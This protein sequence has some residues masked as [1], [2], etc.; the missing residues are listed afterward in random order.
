MLSEHI[1]ETPNERVLLLVTL[2]ES[3]AEGHMTAEDTIPQD[4]EDLPQI[5][6]KTHELLIA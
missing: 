5:L 2:L 4:L 3:T 1:C 6:R